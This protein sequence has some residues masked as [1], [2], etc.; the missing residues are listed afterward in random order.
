MS[1]VYSNAL[2]NI[3]ATG[4]MDSDGGLFFRRDPRLLECPTVK[5]PRANGQ[6]WEACLIERDFW[7]YRFKQSGLLK[8][9]WVLQERFLAPRVLHFHNDQ[10]FWECYEMT[11]SEKHIETIPDA[12]VPAIFKRPPSDPD[13]DYREMWEHAANSYSAGELTQSSDKEAAFYGI[14]RF[15]KDRWIDK[16]IVGLW[17]DSLP[18]SLLWQTNGERRTARCLE[19]RAPS[20]S[21]LSIDGPVKVHYPH[22]PRDPFFPQGQS[23]QRVHVENINVV[24]V[25]QPSSSMIKNAHIRLRGCVKCVRVARRGFR[26]KFV[27]VIDGV[28]TNI[29][30]S[31]DDSSH[32]PSPMSDFFVVI[33]DVPMDDFFNQ[34]SYHGLLLREVAT[35]TENLLRTFE[36]VGF[37]WTRGGNVQVGNIFTKRLIST[38]GDGMRLDGIFLE[39]DPGF[40]IKKWD[41]FGMKGW[42]AAVDWS[43][44]EDIPE[45]PFILFNHG[46]GRMNGKHRLL[47]KLRELSLAQEL[48][49]ECSQ[50]K[51]SQRPHYNQSC[52]LCLPTS[53]GYL[54]SHQCGHSSKGKSV[55][56]HSS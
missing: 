14:V 55:D 34:E 33:I 7:K 23:T 48:C 19:Y 2:C 28:V 20:W 12:Y 31:F 45:E 41:I 11:A 42:A 4:A 1:Y 16:C 53:L 38:L 52:N 22:S 51:H 21:W 37:V 49:D 56:H 24:H 32:D 10:V 35:P 29:S 6:L 8:R 50:K 3:S 40:V 17:E 30:C 27:L 9:A 15:F 25:G 43:L 13:E 39:N 5:I 26:K 54:D 36:R 46:F 44:Y 47:S 18:L